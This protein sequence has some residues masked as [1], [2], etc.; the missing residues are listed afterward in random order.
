MSA[1]FGGNGKDIKLKAGPGLT[2]GDT[3]S[4]SVSPDTVGADLAAL[5]A[6]IEE[7]KIYTDDGVRVDREW[8][9]N[10]TIVLHHAA[11]PQ[12]VLGEGSWFEDL[13]DGET[14]EM[15]FK[16]KTVNPFIQPEEE[17]CCGFSFLKHIKLIEDVFS[18]L[19]VTEEEDKTTESYVQMTRYLLAG[20]KVRATSGTEPTEDPIRMPRLLKE[21]TPEYKKANDETARILP[22]EDENQ[23]TGRVVM[24]YLM[25]PQTDDWYE[26]EHRNFMKKRVRIEMKDTAKYCVYLFYLS[27]LEFA[28]GWVILGVGSL[29]LKGG[30]EAV[31][32]ASVKSPGMVHP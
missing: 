14:Y 1:P 4:F 31:V 7:M 18:F 12:I 16:A 21:G 2:G 32:I 29:Q 19:D 24:R 22:F 9:V 5:D 6:A 17:E 30:S 25:L 13:I 3:L 11:K 28:F 26:V 10:K 15:E 20:G 23:K 8:L 27:L